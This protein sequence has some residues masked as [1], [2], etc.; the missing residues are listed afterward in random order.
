MTENAAESCASNA[1]VACPTSASRERDAHAS[2]SLITREM[3]LESLPQLSAS[4]SSC[5]RPSRVSE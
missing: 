5:R 2:L 1:P 3:A 4:F